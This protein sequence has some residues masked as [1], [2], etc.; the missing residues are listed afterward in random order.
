MIMDAPQSNYLPPLR[1]GDRLTS[2]EFE[3]RY[4]AIPDLKKAELIDGI[5]YVNEPSTMWH[6]QAH[7]DI[8]G[9]LGFYRMGT[10]HLICSVLGTVRLDRKNQVQPDVHLRIA[11]KCGG[12]SRVD[13]DGFVEG[14][15]EL[16]AEVTYSEVSYDLHEKLEVYRRSGV[17]EYV[18]WRLEDEAIDWF[19]LRDGQFVQLNP[20]PNGL[21]RSEIFPG[22]WLDPADL[23]R[24]N[25]GSLYEIVKKGQATPEHETFVVKLLRAG[26]IR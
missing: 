15:P 2:A 10:P 20:C 7:A 8:T 14:A 3:R 1:N 11:A 24:G 6:G 5:V 25:L 23:I 17:R 18:V 21:L 12:Q 26:E 4:H 19:T 13:E 16:I 9:W 22:L